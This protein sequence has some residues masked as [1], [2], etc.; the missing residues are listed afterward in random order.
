MPSPGEN[1]TE[2][3]EAPQNT[4]GMVSSKI[5]SYYLPTADILTDII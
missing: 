3:S 1:K 2:L 4:L 5:Q